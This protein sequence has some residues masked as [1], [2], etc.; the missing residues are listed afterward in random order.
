MYLK[1]PRFFIHL[2]GE[3]KSA[4]ISKLFCFSTKWCR[5]Y[6]TI[7]FA[8]D[9]VTHFHNIFQNMLSLFPQEKSQL[10]VTLPLLQIRQENTFV[11]ILKH[12]PNIL[13]VCVTFQVNNFLMENSTKSWQI[14]YFLIKLHAKI[15]SFRKKSPIVARFD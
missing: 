6:I 9:T 12:E 5:S 3:L 14:V 11:E 4:A 7:T 15:R 8:L 1:L 13:V 2:F 10:Q